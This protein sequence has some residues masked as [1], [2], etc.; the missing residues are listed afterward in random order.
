MTTVSV[1]SD[2]A[3][4]IP[5]PPYWLELWLRDDGLVTAQALV[6]V[7]DLDGELVVTRLIVT[8]VPLSSDEI[9]RIPL[10]RIAA[11][12]K[13][14]YRYGDRQLWLDGLVVATT[15][16]PP[17][18]VEADKRIDAYL[19]W[20]TGEYRQA[21]P[22]QGFFPPE[23]PEQPES[24]PLARPDRRNPEFYRQVA[25][26]YNAAA[27]RSRRPVAVLAAEAGVPHNTARHW[28]REARRRGYLP[29]GRRGRAG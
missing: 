12:A 6:K 17:D 3:P 16:P 4:E 27:S 13:R 20:P 28:I 11:M 24:P 7:D 25:S 15:T 14:V 9:R 8:G 18:L 22:P 26:A 10:A 1:V 19:T 23:R 5:P 2:A 21:D 29:P